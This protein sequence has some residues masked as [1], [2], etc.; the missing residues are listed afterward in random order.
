MN[1]IEEPGALAISLTLRRP[2]RYE[3][4][5][6]TIQ[7]HRK[8]HHCAVEPMSHQDGR[9][10]AVI[11]RATRSS[12]VLEV[13]SVLGYSGLNIVSSFGQTGRLDIVEPDPQ[14]AR[15]AEEAFE[16]FTVAERVRINNSTV[17]DV[18]PALAGLYDLIVFNEGWAALADV[19]EHWLRLVRIGGTLLVRSGAAGPDDQRSVADLLGRIADDDRLDPWFAPRLERVLATRQR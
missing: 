2:D 12:Y 18:V 16:R 8:D 5:R 1:A 17:Q 11:T 15:L 4:V 13:G 7:G 9:E 3:K 19:Y 6:E 10:L 14:H